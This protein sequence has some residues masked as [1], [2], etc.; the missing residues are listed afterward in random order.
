MNVYRVE[1]GANRINF[2][3]ATVDGMKSLGL[4]KFKGTTS[5]TPGITVYHYVPDVPTRGKW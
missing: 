2:S 5:L 1:N 3:K 4:I